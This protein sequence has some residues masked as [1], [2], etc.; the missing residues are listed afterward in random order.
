MRA[1]YAACAIACVLVFLPLVCFAQSRGPAVHA[2]Y[3]GLA[4][5]IERHMHSPDQC[6][7][8][9]RSYMERNADV[10]QKMRSAAKRSKKRVQ[11]GRYEGISV[12]EIEKAKA[13]MGRSK[14]MEVIGRWTELFGAFAQLHPK[15]ATQV[16]E[17]FSLY[18]PQDVGH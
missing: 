6:V 10:L 15:Q 13:R 12:E 8:A 1:R 4:D 14:A 7:D 5:V 18:V 17:L 16:A 11:D 3:S 2:F 9:V